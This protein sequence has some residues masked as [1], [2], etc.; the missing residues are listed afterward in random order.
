MIYELNEL[1]KETIN[2][3]ASDL[4]LTVGLPPTIRVTGKLLKIGE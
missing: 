2:R 4:H 1:L 3:G